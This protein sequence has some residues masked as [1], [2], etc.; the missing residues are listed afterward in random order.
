ML[1][2]SGQ[3]GTFRLPMAASPGSVLRLD[4]NS[5]YDQ[6]VELESPVAISKLNFSLNNCGDVTVVNLNGATYQLV[7]R[8]NF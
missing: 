2:S 4:R 7:F 3:A 6:T 8:S 1:C 5:T